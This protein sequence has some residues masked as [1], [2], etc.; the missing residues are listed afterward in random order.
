MNQ[1]ERSL[2]RN[3]D[4]FAALLEV[5]SA[6]RSTSER[7]L[8]CAIADTVP[9]EQGQTTMPEVGCEPEAGLAPRSSSGKT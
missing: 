9:I 1:R 7:L 8:P 4:Q 6:A 2:P 5:T 3:Q